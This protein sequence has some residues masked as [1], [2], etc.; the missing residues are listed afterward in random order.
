MDGVMCVCGYLCAR[1][2]KHDKILV[3]NV[4]IPR[5]FVFASAAHCN[6]I[7]GMEQ[8]T[9]NQ[10]IYTNR[11][12]YWS[13]HVPFFLSFFSLVVNQYSVCQGAIYR[14]KIKHWIDH[15]KCFQKSAKVTLYIFFCALILLFQSKLFTSHPYRY[16]LNDGLGLPSLLHIIRVD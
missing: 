13:V 14:K 1:C 7:D 2:T 6:F 12:P 8:N 5:A 15:R 10:R 16:V 11:A 4:I 9:T 3:S